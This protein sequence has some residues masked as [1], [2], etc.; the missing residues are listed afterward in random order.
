MYTIVYINSSKYVWD[1][2]KNLAN[3]QRH[4]IDFKEV[5]QIFEWPLIRRI[6]NRKDYGETRWI[7]MG[8]YIN[9]VVVVVYTIRK[10]YIRII[11]ARRANRNERKIY[12]EKCGKEET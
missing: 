7:A 5:C 1:E 6:D 11:S 3:I 4:G 8:W 12:Q 2:R 10:D 9:E